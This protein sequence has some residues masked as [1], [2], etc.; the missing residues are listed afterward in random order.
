METED[1]QGVVSFSR[2]GARTIRLSDLRNH[3]ASELMSRVHPVEN[4]PNRYI[5]RLRMRQEQ[6]R[7]F[8]DYMNQSFAKR[9]GLHL[10]NEYPEPTKTMSTD[11]LNRFIDVGADRAARYGLVNENEIV[12]FMELMIVY[13]REFDETQDW[14]HE[15]L[16]NPELT[17]AEKT[18][19]LREHR[20]NEAADAAIMTDE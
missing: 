15:I 4:A 5:G 8:S 6:I 10:R 11:E 3:P 9:A 18:E 19:A 1:G 20:D 17:A 7:A 14:A 12:S 2:E 13:G 16:Q